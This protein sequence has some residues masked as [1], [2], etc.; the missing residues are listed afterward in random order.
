M[1]PTYAYRCRRCGPF[2]VLAPM[3]AS[4]DERHCPTCEAAAD[5]IVTAPGIRLTAPSV[6][7]A[8]QVEERSRHEPSVTNAIPPRRSVNHPRRDP[9]HAKLPRP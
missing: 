6:A 9:R 8:L 3:V 5:R 2:D 7:H 4:H 1:L